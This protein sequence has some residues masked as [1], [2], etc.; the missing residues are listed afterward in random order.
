MMV[1]FQSG[2]TTI[3]PPKNEWC[4]PLSTPLTPKL[5]SDL[6]FGIVIKND[7]RIF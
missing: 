1:V 4:I 5:G 6:H 7:H 2:P 3:L